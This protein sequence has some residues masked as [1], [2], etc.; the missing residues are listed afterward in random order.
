MEMPGK[1]PNAENLGWRLH[2]RRR[3]PGRPTQRGAFRRRRAW[4]SDTRSLRGRRRPRGRCGRNSTFCLWRW[5]CWTF[6]NHFLKLRVRHSGSL[7][8]PFA[9]RSLPM[10]LP[11]PPQLILLGN[12]LE[13]NTLR[14]DAAARLFGV[15]AVSHCRAN[16]NGCNAR[17][18]RRDSRIFLCT[19]S[20]NGDIYHAGM[21]SLSLSYAAP[22]RFA[23]PAEIFR[24]I[25]LRVQRIEAITGNVHVRTVT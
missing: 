1:S 13:A 18:G 9:P 10:L 19:R 11:W 5:A 7:S 4:R 17:R 2:R 15:V 3:I 8:R 12:S 24:I 6:Y 23:N 25:Y 22:H 20:C 21:A 14:S 16:I